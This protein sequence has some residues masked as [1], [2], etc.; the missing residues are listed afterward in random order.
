[1]RVFGDA[2]GVAANRGAWAVFA[3]LALVGCGG[4]KIDN[5][6]DGTLDSGAE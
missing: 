4:G 5:G 1:M 3:A 2:K 6:A